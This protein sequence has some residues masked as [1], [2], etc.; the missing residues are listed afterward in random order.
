M[1]RTTATIDNQGPAWS[2]VRAN[3]PT[4]A[5][6]AVAAI[7]PAPISIATPSGSP[8]CASSAKWVAT[9]RMAMLTVPMTRLV[10]SFPASTEPRGTGA[11]RTRA[12]VPSRRSSSRLSTPNW[13]AKKR[14]K[15]AIPAA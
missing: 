14:K 13:T 10:R 5:L 4:S 7:T 1:P 2:G 6:T 12:R 11:T 9:A 8:Q 3:V 15:T